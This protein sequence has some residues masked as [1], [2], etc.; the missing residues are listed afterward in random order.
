MKYQAIKHTPLN[1]GG[2]PSALGSEV[3]YESTGLV[4]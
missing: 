4:D 2:P 3:Q 1:A